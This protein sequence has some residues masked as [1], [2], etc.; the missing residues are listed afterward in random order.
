M[1]RRALAIGE[2]ALGAAHPKVAIRLH[3]LAGLL[4]GDGRLQEA[5]AM[6]RRA[7]GIFRACLG[8]THPY[9]KGCEAALARMVEGG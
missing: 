9:T 7:V 4:A 6:E 3:N 1:Y 5:L 2:T 8:D